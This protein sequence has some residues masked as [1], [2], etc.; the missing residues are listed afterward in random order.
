MHTSSLTHKLMAAATALLFS[1]SLLTAHAKRTGE[2][3]P[4]VPVADS[5]AADSATSLVRFETT[6]GTFDIALYNDT[7]LHRDNFL[8][9]VRNGYYDGLLFHRVIRD[10]MVQTGDSTSRTAAPGTPLGEGDAGYTLPAE[11]VF[12]THYHHRGAVA[13][14]RT[15]DD[16][17]PERRSSGAQFYVVWGTTYAKPALSPI[18]R[19][20]RMATG[21]KARFTDEM[22]ADYATRGGTP[23]LDGQYTVFGEV[24][25][26]LDVIGRIQA[27]A[28]DAA[29]RPLTDVRITRATIVRQAGSQPAS[30]R[31]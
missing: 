26:G 4:Q 2:F 31:Q 23:H 14:A 21:G 10:F 9:L 13:A 19:R 5:L 18:R 20:V 22:V 30:K 3:S 27:V 28:T 24:V 6:L 1:A 11:I 8:R 15:G 17:N 16:V 25:R 12:P 29:D 7:P